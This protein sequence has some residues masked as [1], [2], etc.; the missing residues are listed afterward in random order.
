MT[1]SP[2]LIP[3]H[4]FSLSLLSLPLAPSPA[5]LLL[6]DT[7][8]PIVTTMHLSLHPCI[9]TSDS[10]ALLPIA[11]LSQSRLLGGEEARRRRAPHYN[12]WSHQTH[13]R[14]LAHSS[15]LLSF[16]ISLRAFSFFA[17]LLLAAAAIFLVPVL[18]I[19]LL[20]YLPHRLALALALALSIELLFA[21]CNYLG[22]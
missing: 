17:F 15:L 6:H 14:L 3:F 18:F 13:H 2:P 8:S 20:R 9:Y 4:P 19:F 22:E 16:S 21:C 12:T 7:M 1:P 5:P 10:D 11:L